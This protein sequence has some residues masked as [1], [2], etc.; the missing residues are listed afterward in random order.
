MLKHTTIQDTGR[1]TSSSYTAVLVLLPFK[2]GDMD[3]SADNQPSR[4]ENT[5]TGAHTAHQK[6][7]DTSTEWTIEILIDK[8]TYLKYIKI[9][10]INQILK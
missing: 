10:N 3:S 9:F 2:F 7:W 4:T 8:L 1:E 6:E 5:W